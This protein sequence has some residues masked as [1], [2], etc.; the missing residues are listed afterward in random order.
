MKKEDLIKKLEL[1][2]DGIEVCLFDYEL[3]LSDDCGNGSTKGIYDTFDVEIIDLDSEEEKEFYEE[4]NDKKFVSW[5]AL[6]FK[7]DYEE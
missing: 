2:P 1:I 5:A 7:N 3:N 4:T 6:S